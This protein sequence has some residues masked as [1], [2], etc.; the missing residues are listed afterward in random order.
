M[1]RCYFIYRQV[2]LQI[3]KV[4]ILHEEANVFVILYLLWHGIPKLKTK[5]KK[6][7]SEEGYLLHIEKQNHLF[8]ITNNKNFKRAAKNHLF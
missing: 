7:K 2:N 4:G 6:A 3:P 8:K 5:P 1:L